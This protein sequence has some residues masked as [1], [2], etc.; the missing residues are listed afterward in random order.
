VVAEESDER[1]NVSETPSDDEEAEIAKMR[2][3][4]TKAG[5]KKPAAKKKA[6]AKKKN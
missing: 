3:A 2:E 1:D 4:A 5:A 6:P